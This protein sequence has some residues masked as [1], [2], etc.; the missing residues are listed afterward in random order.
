MCASGVSYYIVV[1]V[2]AEKVRAT[3]PPPALLGL[4]VIDRLLIAPSLI[5]ML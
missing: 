3:Q 4:T 2:Y 1:L 5:Q